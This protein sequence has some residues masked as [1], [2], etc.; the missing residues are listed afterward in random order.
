MND[1]NQQKEF[2]KLNQFG[3]FVVAGISVVCALLHGFFPNRLDE[4]TAMF[5]AVAV[6]ALVIHQITKFKGFGIEVEK[7]VKQL[8]VD[9]RS[10]ESAVGDLEKDVGPGSKTAIAPSAA[11]P[12]VIEA[13][14]TTNERFVNPDDPNKGQFGGLPE[15]NGR[16][17]TATIEPISGPKSSRCR[18][19]IRVVSTDPARP[20]IGKVKLHLHPTFGQWWSYDLD[21]KGGVAEENISSYGAFTIGAEADDGKTRLELDLMDVPGGTKRFYE[22]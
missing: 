5:L 22:E 20:L 7:A 19:K 6:V 3:L 1:E 14:D 2:A 17:L 13:A 18:V 11:A 9:V 21:A 4:K 16:R 10:V 8:K 15:S 12:L